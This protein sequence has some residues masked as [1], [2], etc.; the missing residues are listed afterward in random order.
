MKKIFQIVGTVCLG[1]AAIITIVG[2]ASVSGAAVEEMP[3]SMKNKR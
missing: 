1:L 2:P 3:E